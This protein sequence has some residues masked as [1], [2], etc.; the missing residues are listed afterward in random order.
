MS[1]ELCNLSVMFVAETCGIVRQTFVDRI[2][3]FV[4]K[5]LIE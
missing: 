5:L 1:F 4:M 3:E 2:Q